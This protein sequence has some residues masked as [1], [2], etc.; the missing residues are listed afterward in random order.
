MYEYRATL[1]RI[2]DG[3]T[4]VC[5]VDVGFS[6]HT[7]QHLRLARI[8]APETR[9]SEK[10]QGKAATKFLETLMRPGDELIIHTEKT[11]KYGRYLA[12]VFKDGAL[13]N[14]IMVRAG[15][16]VPWSP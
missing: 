13:I 16:A 10:E 15:H 9:G 8:D 5:L 11:G 3:D 12:N 1:E 14:E 2:V 6:F 7:K 4:I